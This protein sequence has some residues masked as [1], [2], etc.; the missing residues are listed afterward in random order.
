MS[1]TY[2]QMVDVLT[3]HLG[4]DPKDISPEVTFS[5]LRLDSLSLVEL[6]LILE[7]QYGIG[8]KGIN[9]KGTLAEVV[10]QLEAQAS[11]LEANGESSGH[12]IVS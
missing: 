11:A 1:E 12:G 9:L 7:D 10:E 4:L 3:S 8:T 2:E 6:G 5:D